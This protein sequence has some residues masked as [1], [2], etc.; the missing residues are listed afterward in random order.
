MK[1][2]IEFETAGAVVGTGA[3]AKDKPHFEINRILKEQ[4]INGMESMIDVLRS[5]VSIRTV[6]C[7]LY[8][9]WNHEAGT[10]TLRKK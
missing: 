10:I 4:A 9:K 2:S 8:D 6:S 7:P 5:D 3:F 1:I